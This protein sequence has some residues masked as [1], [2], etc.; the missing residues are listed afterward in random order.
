MRS[1][2][3]VTFESAC[4]LFEPL[5]AAGVRRDLAADMADAPTLAASL[6]RLRECLTANAFTVGG[7]RVSLERVARAFD[8]V[9][10][11]EG[12]HVLNDW[13]GKSDRVNENSI[14]VDVLD[15]IVRERGGDPADAGVVAVLIDY[16]L[17]H[18]LELFALRAWD[19]G[20]ADENL[21]RIAALLE[22]LQGPGGSGQA[23]VNGAESL[24]LLATSHFE[25]HERGYA[26]LLDRVRTLNRDH[27]T[28][29]AVSHAAS[30]GSHLRF[31]FEA[32]YA[33]DTIF[34]RDD[35]VADYPWLCFALLNVMRALDASRNVELRTENLELRTE[36]LELGTQSA[37]PLVEAL[38][39]GLSADARAF[40]GEPPPSLTGAEAERAE[41]SERFHAR[42]EELLGAF[43]PFRPNEREYSPLSFFFNFAHNVRKG[44]V[45]DALL[46]RQP[47]TVS[48]D[49]L[50]TGLP[51]GDARNADKHA[52]A[53]TLMTYARLNPDRI[54]GQLMP[55]IVY[56]PAAGRQA[57]GTTL[58]RLKS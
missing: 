16:Y 33:R 3:A 53:T 23:F 6:G 47:W 9:T 28:R 12:F 22:Q 58:R 51:R 7:R 30:M 34:M 11:E 43:E 41:F 35:N 45:V 37:E 36:N 50:L 29:I 56:D 57:F 18:V 24:L 17:V 27:Q 38:L 25:L 48:F 44:A 39:N 49:D 13:D 15:Y 14:P 55:V 20:D 40:V 21:D 26:L 5:V 19:A 10:R 52:L 31:G 46:R 1:S 42:R 54:R 4:A 8:R 2:A 32:S